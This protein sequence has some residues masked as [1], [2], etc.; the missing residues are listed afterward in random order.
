MSVLVINLSGLF[1]VL[2]GASVGHSLI[3]KRKQSFDKG[4][5]Y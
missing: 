1:M 2:L 3:C 5:L 4:H